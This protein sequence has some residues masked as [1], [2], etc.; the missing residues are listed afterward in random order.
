M[1]A[2]RMYFFGAH[3]GGEWCM[4][5]R[6]W[7][8][9]C[10]QGTAVSWVGEGKRCWF[11]WNPEMPVAWGVFRDEDGRRWIMEPEEGRLR[12]MAC[13]PYLVATGEVAEESGE[14]HALWA[15]LS[16]RGR[17]DRVQ[18]EGILRELERV[19]P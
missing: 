14:A 12:Y 17:L 13:E 11:S 5:L 7:G 15:V 3:I 2:E 6:P 9:V 8:M 18:R 19:A 1:S 4:R 10:S 16:F